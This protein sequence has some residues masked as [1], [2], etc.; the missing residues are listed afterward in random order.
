MNVVCFPFAVLD[1]NTTIRL[2]LH[3][4]SDQDEVKWSVGSSI[5]DFKG[6]V[7]KER[8]VDV[9]AID[10]SEFIFRLNHRVKLLKMDIEGA[11]YETLS[12]LI[13]RGLHRLVDYI[14]VETHEQKIPELR[15]K[16]QILLAKIAEQQI[17]NIDLTW[18]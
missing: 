1:R 2:Y 3:E 12:R 11:E 7:T 5:L 13:D 15:D 10:L 17:A 9:P 8:Y 4:W 18:I 14:L 16:H 6:N